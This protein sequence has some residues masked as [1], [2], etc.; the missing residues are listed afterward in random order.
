MAGDATVAIERS[1][2]HVQADQ[3]EGPD[4][5]GVFMTSFELQ[6]PTRIGAMNR[7]RTKDEHEVDGEDRFMGSSLVR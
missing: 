6:H 5:G 2:V 1:K 4:C 3:I 7:S